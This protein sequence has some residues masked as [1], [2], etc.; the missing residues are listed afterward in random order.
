VSHCGI[1]GKQKDEV[2]EGSRKLHNE[3][4]HDLYYSPSIFTII[5]SRRMRWAGHGA[6]MGE[7]EYI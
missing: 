5:Q 7:E 6:R 4:L 3:E 1:F 2:T